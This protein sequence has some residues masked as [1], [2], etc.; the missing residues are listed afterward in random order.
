MLLAV[1][2]GVAGLT[3]LLPVI[4][5]GSGRKVAHSGSAERQLS[6]PRARLP[7]ILVAEKRIAASTFVKPEELK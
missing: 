7:K 1:A 5:L 3:A 2:L 6:Q 4:S